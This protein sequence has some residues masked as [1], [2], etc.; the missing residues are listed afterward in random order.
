MCI[1]GFGE[2]LEK[3]IKEKELSNAELARKLKV[4]PAAI[5]NYIDGTFMPST[6]NLARL[7]KVLNISSDWLLGLTDD[8]KERKSKNG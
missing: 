8:Y 6:P 5:N 4:R 3:V 2:R 1:Y 7:C